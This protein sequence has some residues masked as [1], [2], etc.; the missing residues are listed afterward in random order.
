MLYRT[1]PKN[2]DSL[3]ILGFGCMRLPTSEGKIDE[4]R[5]IAQIKYSID[6]GVNYLD[7]AWPYHG[8]ASEPLLGKALKGGYREKVKVA[9]KLPTWKILTREDMDAYLNKQI[10]KLGVER[11]DYYLVHALTGSSWERLVSLGAVDFLNKALSDGRI[12][13]AGF[14]YHGLPEEFAPIV[15]SYPWT[16]CQI[17]YNYL[18]EK[19]QAGTAG[20]EHAA[21]MGLGVI[22]MEPLRG[23][24]IGLAT[25]PPEVQKIW[26]ESKAARTPAE[27]ALRWVWNHPEVTVVLSGMNE[28]D[29]I[30]ENIR[31][32]ESANANSMSPEEL[33]IV[34]RARD[35]YQE[36]LKVNCTGCGY[37]M[38]CSS[39]V[40]IPGCF[41][42]YNK[43]H[44][45][46]DE[47]GVRFFYAARMAGLVSNG[48]TTF[49]SQCVECAECMEKCPQHLP[50]PDLLKQVA[51]E[52]E[53]PDLKGRIE[54]ARSFFSDQ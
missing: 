32:A 29:H 2:G 49:A 41:E 23:G 13:N 15:D 16:F 26:D 14:S 39:D 46:G 9:T 6:H 43:M 47:E 1:M 20:L 28:E 27:W 54:K 38:P 4:K 21:K 3:S 51:E 50:I 17:Q 42:L 19:N 44:M 37:C 24:N 7:T 12:S 35:K 18:D 48:P 40:L 33:K 30:R 11:I 52:M 36:L 10:E 5:A 53:G 25:P 8:G 34:E 45:F 22:V 31:V